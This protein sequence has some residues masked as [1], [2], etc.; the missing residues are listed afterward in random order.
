MRLFRKDNWRPRDSDEETIYI[1]TYPLVAR[2][3]RKANLTRQIIRRTW[4]GFSY[5]VAVTAVGGLIVVAVVYLV[6]LAGGSF[7][8]VP[9]AVVAAA[10]AVA[11]ASAGAIYRLAPKQL[12]RAQA[13]EILDAE[14]G[15]V[16]SGIK[17]IAVNPPYHFDLDDEGVDWHIVDG[18]WDLPEIERTVLAVRYG[19][20][21]TLEAIGD[22][23]G[24]SRE[25]IRQLEGR[26]LSAVA[27]SV[28]AVQ[29]DRRGQQAHR[30]EDG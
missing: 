16:V 18:L 9:L 10:G 28:R 7:R 22:A 13:T 24:L 25:R 1:T 14:P 11:L 23:L 3:W 30:S 20:P 4:R 19:R 26:A 8:V 6:G 15:R 12:L 21:M 2:T 17:K 5:E 29:D 27:E